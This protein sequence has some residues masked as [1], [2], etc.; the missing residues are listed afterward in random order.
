MKNIKNKIKVASIVCAWPPAAGGIGNSAYQINQ[1]LSD[2]VEIVNFTPGKNLRPWLQKGHGAFLP[3]LLWRLK[4]FDYLYFHYP[5]FGTSEIIYLFKK[6]HKKR[7][8][9]I[10]HYHM[11]VKNS[12]LLSKILSLPSR[13]LRRSLLNQADIIVTASLDY[14][15]HSQIRKYYF[16]HP[17]KFREI[18]FS[19]DLQKFQP[20]SLNQSSSNGLISYAQKIVHYVN[21]EFIKK[22]QRQLLFVG[23]LDRAHYFKGLEVL[24]IALSKLK[25]KNWKLVIVGEGDRR[26]H[27]EKLSEKLALTKKIEFRGKLSATD[28][29]RTYQEADLLLLPSINTNEAFGLVIIEALACGVPV[30]A[31]NLPGVRQVFNNEQEGLLVNPGNSEDLK[32]KLEFILNHENSRRKMAQA[33]RELAEKRYDQEKIKKDLESLFN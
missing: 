5:F 29:I 13:I 8:K 31:S 22:N 28:L 12:G 24:F 20:K 1:L 30:I 11:D 19:L 15:K 14:I 32:N 21:N 17:E 4:D 6:L 2:R 3:Q 18:P 9:L 16:A 26:K 10:I 23:G 33:A 7:P 27:Y 25:T